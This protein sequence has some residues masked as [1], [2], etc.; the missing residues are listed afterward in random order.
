[1]LV[2]WALVLLRGITLP[3]TLELPTIPLC[4][5][6]THTSFHHLQVTAAILH[7]YIKFL[8]NVVWNSS[9]RVVSPTGTSGVDESTNT[10]SPAKMKGRD[11]W[12][13]LRISDEDL[14]EYNEKFRL[15]LSSTVLQPL[16]AE[17]QRINESLTA[18]GLADA[19]I[20]KIAHF[21]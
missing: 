1:M 14:L 7:Y 20:G 5:K 21:F 9:K 11:I 19:R 16:K 15:W 10:K 12:Q 17:I 18:H 8:W 13:Q 4:W 6:N 2:G 3:P